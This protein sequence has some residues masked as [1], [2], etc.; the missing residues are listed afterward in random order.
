MYIL[1]F[2]VR[3]FVRLFSGFFY[4]S[5]FANL[6]SAHSEHFYFYTFSLFCFFIFLDIPFMLTIISFGHIHKSNV[7]APYTYIHF[8]CS[9]SSTLSYIHTFTIAAPY[10][11]TPSS[12]LWQF[13]ILCVLF[14]SYTLFF[15]RERKTVF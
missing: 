12:P 9:Y 1:S 2:F 10:Y 14:F 15:F 5:K 3:P 11:T 4:Y 8:W 7:N 13:W 6:L